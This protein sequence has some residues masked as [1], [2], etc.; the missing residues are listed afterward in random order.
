MKLS[1][2]CLAMYSMLFH[3]LGPV[4]AGAR[5]TKKLKESDE[6]ENLVISVSTSESTSDH[7]QISE[8][9]SDAS[10]ESLKKSIDKLDTELKTLGKRTVKLLNNKVPGD[11]HREF[12]IHSII[13]A[14]DSYVCS[15]CSDL[16]EALEKSGLYYCFDDPRILD[17]LLLLL[18]NRVYVSFEEISLDDFKNACGYNRRYQS[19]VD[20]ISD[21]ERIIKKCDEEKEV[22][23]LDLGKAERK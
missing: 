17:E 9:E 10:Y 18:H 13:R 23:E 1:L 4:I 14:A 8:G 5:N 6:S 2:S 3:R 22:L 19:A 20:D 15:K 11:C 7:D 21:C 12:D 16:L